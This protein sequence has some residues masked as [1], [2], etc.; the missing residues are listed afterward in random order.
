MYKFIF[1]HF[2]SG[3][4]KTHLAK[5]FV[6]DLVSSRFNSE[7]AIVNAPISDYLT[8]RD[9]HRVVLN[10]PLD[11]L[12]SL[13]SLNRDTTIILED[14][15]SLTAKQARFLRTCLNFYSHHKKQKYFCVA[16]SIFKT[17]LYSM[18]PFFHF[19]IFPSHL[20]N[21]VTIR[22]V[23]QYFK[24]SP[25]IVH[26]ILAESKR[27]IQEESGSDSGS[28]NSR[29]RFHKSFLFLNCKKLIFY[30]CFDV[31][32]MKSSMIK[33]G[34]ITGMPNEQGD[35]ETDTS[36]S[37]STDSDSDIGGGGNESK[38]TLTTRF[39]QLLS[40]FEQKEIATNIFSIIVHVIPLKFVRKNDLTFSFSSKRGLVRVSLV[41]YVTAL[42]ERDRKKYDS[43]NYEQLTALH[44]F[45]NEKATIPRA[46]IKNEFFCEQND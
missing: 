23:L 11:S 36:T 19:I 46:L 4:G 13:A 40:N 3:T 18:L 16:H 24:F 29:R 37:S 32:R 35:D 38:H 14:L 1:K 34:S 33:L 43:S 9:Q 45:V 21:I 12:E 5:I 26:S 28:R 22:N 2:R 30:F 8:P 44:N 41:D 7:V 10:V 42:L 39:T 27:L 25:A 17:S 20:A 6:D 15:I 31:D